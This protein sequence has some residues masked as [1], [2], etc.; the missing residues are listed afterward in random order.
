M[1]AMRCR[2]DDKGVGKDKTLMTL[3][4][5]FKLGKFSKVLVRKTHLNFPDNSKSETCGQTFQ[6]TVRI[7]N[8]N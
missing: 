8:S 7:D 5:V 2:L 3:Y 4:V 6:L 1:S